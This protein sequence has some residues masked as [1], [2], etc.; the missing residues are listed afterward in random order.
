[1]FKYLGIEIS[2]SA[3]SPTHILQ[4]RLKAAKT[5]FYRIRNNAQLLG[6]SNCRVRLQLVSSLVVSILMFGAP[7][8]ACLSDLTMGFSPSDRAFR[9]VEVFQRSLIRWALRAHRDTRTS[10]LCLAS[11]GSTA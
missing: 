4:S 10:I 6:L 2:S 1:M 3:R 5:A 9:D 7:L 8:Y 11:K